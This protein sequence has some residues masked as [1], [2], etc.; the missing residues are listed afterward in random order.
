M[1]APEYTPFDMDCR[2]CEYE[3]V[4]FVPLKLAHK[5]TRQWTRLCKQGRKRKMMRQ[6]TLAEIPV[7]C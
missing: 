4:C 5:I 7:V 6:S 3:P 1:D 2:R